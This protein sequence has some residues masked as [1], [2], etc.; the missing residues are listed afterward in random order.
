MLKRNDNPGKPKKLNG[1]YINLDRCTNRRLSLVSRLE[2]AGI[3]SSDYLRFSGIEPI[4]NEPQLAKGLQNKGELGI[5]K[6]MLKVFRQV[7]VGEFD[8]VVHIVEDDAAFSDQLSKTL[9]SIKRLML[10]KPPL[11]GADIVFLDYFL[12][13]ELFNQINA[14]RTNLAPGSLEIAQASKSYLGCTA[15]FLLKRS[16]ANY[17]ASILESILDTS[18]N[19]APIDI[20]LRSLIRLGAINAQMSV[21]PMGAV[22][23]ESDA[24]STIQDNADNSK[25]CAHRAHIL[26]R[27]IM[28][29]IESP[30]WCAEKLADL[31]NIKNPLS[32]QSNI[33]DF[34]GF[35][36][37]LYSKMPHF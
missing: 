21:P 34:L 27:L 18:D 19:L 31:N 37:S 36:D 13:R 16:S 17:I 22:S 10:S 24:N 20:T 5:W 9:P 35:F 32:S 6:S 30:F 2:A 26:L 29:G 1:V 8:E 11:G 7:A 15:S 12:N 4:G 23:W 25:K 28:A 3:P 14:R 33:E